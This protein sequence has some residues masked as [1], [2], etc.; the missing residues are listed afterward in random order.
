MQNMKNVVLIARAPTLSISRKRCSEEL[1]MTLKNNTKPLCN[2]DIVHPTDFLC[3][4]KS[5]ILICDIMD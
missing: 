3:V 2:V 4:T 5:S 1:F